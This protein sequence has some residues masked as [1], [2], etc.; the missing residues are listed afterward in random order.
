M[1]YLTLGYD[2]RYTG[3]FAKNLI[4]YHM[5]VAVISSDVNV[6][7]LAPLSV[8]QHYWQSSKGDAREQV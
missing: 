5:Q 7:E 1:L 6:V 3:F 2:Y 8:S 4:Q